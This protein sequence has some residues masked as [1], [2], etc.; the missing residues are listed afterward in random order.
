MRQHQIYPY[1]RFVQQATRAL[2]AFPYN[3]HMA[4]LHETFQA[5]HEPSSNLFHDSGAKDS[6]ADL[7]TVLLFGRNAARHHRPFQLS[8]CRCREAERSESEYQ[9]LQMVHLEKNKRFWLGFQGSEYNI[10]MSILPMAR[11]P[12]DEATDTGQVPQAALQNEKIRLARHN[13][14]KPRT[15]C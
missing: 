9:A 10:S 1:H 4:E 12:P 13:Q 11:A 7:Q 5:H 2:G 3:F 6:A 8:D 15:G 14:D